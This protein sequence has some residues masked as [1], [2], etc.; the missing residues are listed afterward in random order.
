M[1]KIVLQAELRDTGRH[2]VRVLRDVERVPAVVYGGHVAPKVIA[3]DAKL[4]RKALH[5]V[6]A[7]LV[8]LQ[9]GTDTPVHALVREVQHHPV[10]HHILHVDFQAVSMT[11][12]LRLNIPILPE[13]T[14]PVMSNQDIVLVRHMATVEV[15]CLPGDI[16]NHLVADLAKLNGIHDEITVKDLVMPAGLKVIADP[17]QV[18][19][20]VTLSRAAVEEEVTPTETTTAD[21]VEVV[22]KGKIKEGE[23][24]A[25]AKK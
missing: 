12:K 15:E 2:P 1:E 14:A 19:F 6:G 5:E 17:D 20:S 16:P 8:S 4:L 10:K 7:G 11:E 13:G 23:E 9:I 24:E 3:L 25:P 21:Q 22:A 18:L